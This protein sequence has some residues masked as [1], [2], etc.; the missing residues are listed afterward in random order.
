MEKICQECG[1]IV[2]HDGKTGYWIENAYDP[3]LRRWI[4]CEHCLGT[5]IRTNTTRKTMEDL[6]A[7]EFILAEV[8]GNA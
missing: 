1:G 6:L 3:E 4:T 5:G 7:D 8:A 2:G